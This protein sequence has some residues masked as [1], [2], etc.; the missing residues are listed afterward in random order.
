M[1]R[2]DT[3]MRER[4]AG[5]LRSVPATRDN[6]GYLYALI[7]NEDLLVAGFEPKDLPCHEL[8]VLM[9]AGKVSNPESV[10]RMRQKVQEECPEMRGAGY[11]AKAAKAAKVRGA[12]NG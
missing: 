6:D 8:F 1:V 7:L 4:V 3:T 11:R 9:K 12:I 2:L 10:R 5:L